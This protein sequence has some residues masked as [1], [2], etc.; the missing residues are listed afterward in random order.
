MLWHVLRAGAAVSP[1]SSIV[2]LS[3]TIAADSAWQAA[4]FDV[5]TA[6]QDPPLGTADAVISA[7][8]LIDEVDWIVVLFA[9][10]PL[11]TAEAVGKL[12]AGARD[13]NAKVTILT[14]YMDDALGYARIDRDEQGR[15]CRIVERKDDDPGKRGG[16]IEINS[17]MMVVDARWARQTLPLIQ[18]SPVTGEYYLPELVRMAVAEHRE[19]EPWPVQSVPGDPE[20][21][22]GVN[23]RIEQAHA[24]SVLRARARR[25]HLLAGVTLVMPETISIDDDV[26]I[27]AD[28]TILPFTIIERGTRIGSACQIG[29]HAVI[30]NAVIGDGVTVRSS[31]IVNSSMGDG[32]DI[33]P[34]SHLRNGAEI[35]PRVHLGNFAEVKNSVIGPETLIGHF[36]YLGDAT[37]GERVNVGAGTITCNFNGVAKNRTVIGDDVFIGSDTMLVAPVELGAGS[38]TGAGAVVNRNVPPGATVVGVPA[39]PLV[40]SPHPVDGGDGPAGSEG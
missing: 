18:P 1:V 35:G 7:L 16:R 22:L 10:H 36:S 6:I 12:M 13:A 2:V 9:D 32:A 25:R 4:G 21:L 23:D 14:C 38:R 19:G 37:V 17:G 20:D 39:K 31:T 40:K 26:V 30:R 29:P 15:L 27:G 24:D 5:L 11:L 3:P 34:Y 8:P 28:T 33:G